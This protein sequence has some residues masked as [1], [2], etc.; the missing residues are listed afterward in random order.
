ME[1]SWLADTA[2]LVLAFRVWNATAC[3]LS[4]KVVFI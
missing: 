2:T 3:L 4:S 1:V